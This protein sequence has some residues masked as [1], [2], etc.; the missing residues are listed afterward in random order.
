MAGGHGQNIYAIIDHVTCDEILPKDTTSE[1]EIETARL[2]VLRHV[3]H[4]Q[5]TSVV[6]VSLLYEF[7]NKLSHKTV[8]YARQL[9][10]YIL[11]EFI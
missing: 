7:A 4:S 9:A 8:N 11:F 3:T 6:H 5:L 2:T 10:A 1:R